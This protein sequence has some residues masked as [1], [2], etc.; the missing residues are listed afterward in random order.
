MS[1][2]PSGWPRTSADARIWYQRWDHWAR[3]D[4][5]ADKRFLLDDFL[6]DFLE[7]ARKRGTLTYSELGTRY[8]L[9]NHAKR[10]AV[11]E[12]AGIVGEFARAEWGLFLSSI[13]VS[14]PSKDHGEGTYHQGMPSGGLFTL[15]DIPG[16]VSRDDDKMNAPLSDDDRK[17]AE[18]AQ[19]EVW[20]YFSGLSWAEFSRIVGTGYGEPFEPPIP[21]RLI[22]IPD[23]T[24]YVR[25]VR[26]SE[27]FIPEN[28]RKLSKAFCEWLQGVYAF[29]RP[30]R[31][32]GYR[33]IE[34]RFNGE[35]YL[36]ELKALPRKNPK[37]ARWAIREAIGQLLDYEHYPGSG[38]SYDH[39]AIV[40][41][42]RP[43]PD[44]VA[45]L[46]LL[47][48]ILK[49]PVEL[50]WLNEARVYTATWSRSALAQKAR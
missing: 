17:F 15:N 23:P 44:A 49:N 45:W 28:H 42:G 24:G 37:E 4:R 26:A 25:K 20:D 30:R 13:L 43:M 47:Q 16:P 35:D 48:K 36:F 41:D 39:R 12:V 31:E 9:R 6:R 27:A 38:H 46:G 21:D 3:F 14:K 22:E 10:A 2:T 1:V 5:P 19:N 29:E 40:L 7:T 34:W 50:F 8:R 33:D 32:I 18:H 11:G